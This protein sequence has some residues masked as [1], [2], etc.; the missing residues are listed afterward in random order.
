MRVRDPLDGLWCDEDFA[1][2]YPSD[3]RSRYLARPADHPS[4]CRSCQGRLSAH[5]YEAV[6]TT[7]QAIRSGGRSGRIA[8]V[9]RRTEPVP[10]K[11]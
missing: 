11:G 4:A 9:E 2:W 8:S 10:E 1:G 7:A 3:G 6:C 5:R